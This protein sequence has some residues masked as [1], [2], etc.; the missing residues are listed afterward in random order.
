MASKVKPI[1]MALMLAV[2]GLAS[3][4][5]GAVNIL[6]NGGGSTAA[7]NSVA[8]AGIWGTGHAPPGPCGSNIWTQKNGATGHDNR[9]SFTNPTNSIPDAT[10]N[11]WLEWDN[12]SSPTVICAYIAVDSAVGQRLFM[13]NPRGQLNAAFSCSSPPAGGNLVPGLTDAALSTTVCNDIF[14]ATGADQACITGSNCVFNAAPTDIRPEDALWA[15]ERSY[16]AL[17]VPY[18]CGGGQTLGYSPG[19][20]PGVGVNI[21]SSF[22]STFSTPVLF[23]LSGNDPI[24]GL[25]VSTW[26]TA[27][28]GAQAELII[29]NT[30]DT[31]A[32][33]L[34]SA[35]L[36]NITSWQ[37]GYI[38]GGQATTT[39][40][41]VP[42]AS[43]T[44]VT[45]LHVLNRE[46]TSGTYN[47]FEYNEI[48]QGRAGGFSQECGITNPTGGSPYNP[49][50]IVAASGGTR[51]RVIGNGQMSTELETTEDGIGYEFFSFGNVAP[52]IGL[53]KYLTVDG[54]EPLYA[55][56]SANPN[57]PGQFPPCTTPPCTLTFPNVS[58]GSYPIWNVLRVT[59]AFPEPTGIKTLFTDA[60]TQAKNEVSDFLPVPLTVL[61][62]HY[63][64]PL[65]TNTAAN[66]LLCSGEIQVGGDM[67]GQV[68][69]DTQDKNFIMN[70]GGLGSPNG[71]GGCKAGRSGTL[72]QE[73]TGIKGWN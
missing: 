59:T 48:A 50:D 60:E 70:T 36:K 58:N 37:A 13:A 47:S 2:F 49:L 51:Q 4:A 38:W 62:S 14:G 55:T 31:S 21:N 29:V 15:T 72:G 8:I 28:V 46:P 12:S 5:L 35:S 10:G 68:V 19:P 7:F 45:P 22:S 16:N 39:E 3:S 61:R 66:G 71:S 52:L 11:V 18:A 6:F 33:G 25:P 1:L 9:N 34:G 32:N 41:I 44:S 20:A 23:A 69:T 17:P 63:T 56:S 65:Q 40:F 73:I 64:D 26:Q 30:S 57:G 24:S 54:V 42:G 53:D 27:D 43:E 67:G